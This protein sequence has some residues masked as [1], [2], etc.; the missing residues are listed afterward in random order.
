MPRHNIISPLV[1]PTNQ[2]IAIV[3]CAAGIV[4]IQI[5]DRI[6]I[7]TNSIR[8]TLI[9]FSCHKQYYCC[10]LHFNKICHICKKKLWH[11]LNEH[12][13]VLQIT[14]HTHTHTGE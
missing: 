5:H 3:T 12:R 14:P 6:K 2:I 13:T 9:K 10:R 7:I 8:V 1:K 4:Q 11:G